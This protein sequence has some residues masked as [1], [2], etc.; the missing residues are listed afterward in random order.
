[1]PRVSGRHLRAAVGLRLMEFGILQA[2]CLVDKSYAAAPEFGKAF[3]H[4]LLHCG[5]KA[6]IDALET[7]L[8]LGPEMTQPTRD[9]LYRFGNTSSAS[10]W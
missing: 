5:G 2:K 4:I 8:K 1:M 3:D 9:A 7:G 6:I 10:T